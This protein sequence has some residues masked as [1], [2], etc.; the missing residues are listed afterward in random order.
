MADAMAA[1]DA[2]AQVA[3]LSDE[4]AELRAQAQRAE[5][6][7]QAERDRLAREV[8]E[9]EACA[10]RAESVA[11]AM[12]EALDCLRPD[13]RQAMNRAAQQAKK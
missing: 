5:R 4:V 3:A 6:E 7:H 9:V 8:G 13:V 11:D 10:V 1:R 2:A 12:R